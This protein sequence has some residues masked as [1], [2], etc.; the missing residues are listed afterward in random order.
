MGL[1]EPP[2]WQAEKRTPGSGSWRVCASIGTRAISDQMQTKV[3]TIVISSPGDVDAERDAVEGVAADLNQIFRASKVPYRFVVLRWERDA[4][5]GM[6]RSGPQGRIDEALQIPECDFLVGIFW[7]RFG[8]PVVG[9]GSGTEHEIRQAIASWEKKQSPQVLVYFN[10]IPFAP[11]TPEERAQYER[12][13]AFEK[14]LLASENPP[15]VKRY[16]GPDQFREAVLR[17]LLGSVLN[18]N[19]TANNERNAPLRFD[20]TAQ[21]VQV[22]SEGC[23]ELL[24]NIFVKCTY[25]TDSPPSVLPLWFSLVVYLN[26]NV[27]SR[28]SGTPGMNLISETLLIEVG[29]PGTTEV[30]YGVASGNT[31]I[32]NRIELKDMKPG[33]TR[34]FRIT[35]L[36]CSV[37]ILSGGPVKAAVS[38]GGHVAQHLLD[39]ATV[40]PALSFAVRSEEPRRAEHPANA[41]GTSLVYNPVVLT[42]KEGFPNAFKTKSSLFSMLFREGPSLVSLCESSAEGPHT[43]VPGSS[44]VAGVADCGTRFGVRFHLPYLAVRLFVSVHNI[45]R[46]SANLKAELLRVGADLIG[47]GNRLTV[48]GTEMCEVVVKDSDAWVEWELIERDSLNS[49]TLE[50]SAALA[51]EEHIGD[52]S[53][54]FGYSVCGELAPAYQ[55]GAEGW[56]AASSTLPIPRFVGHLPA[57]QLRITLPLARR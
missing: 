6:H 27:T 30:N 57:T 45:D 52:R 43:K 21:Q 22:R 7:K 29:R 38:V 3:L 39:L 37:Y 19:Q 5:P 4:I 35:N 44:Y 20:V 36:R 50:F 47:T 48:G 41:A 13:K 14:E 18:L 46:T 23:S 26:T 32:F 25:T 17:H 34:T 12:L 31:V 49:V 54:D 55:V 28:L 53:A 2:S 24:G 33:E 9:S 1:A 10:E 11:E 8:T 16:D 40:A 15:L 56:G 42:F 51:Y